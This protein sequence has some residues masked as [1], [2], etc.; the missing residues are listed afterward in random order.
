MCAKGV[1]I[2]T[3]FLVGAELK[4]GKEVFTMERDAFFSMPNE[5]FAEDMLT[6]A[7]A[8]YIIKGEQIYVVGEDE[9][10]RAHV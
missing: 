10:G 5:D 3:C 4:D 9:I 6:K 2:G 7:G 1:D 8:F